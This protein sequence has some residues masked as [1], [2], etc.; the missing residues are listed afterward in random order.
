[1]LPVRQFRLRFSWICNEKIGIWKYI[2]PQTSAGC[3]FV[4]IGNCL[5]SS[6]W[7]YSGC[8]RCSMS[9]GCQSNSSYSQYCYRARTHRTQAPIQRATG[10]STWD[11]R[12]TAAT[13]PLRTTTDPNRNNTPWIRPPPRLFCH[14]TRKSHR[15]CFNRGFPSIF[16]LPGGV[17]RILVYGQSVRFYY[18]G[19]LNS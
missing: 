14:S 16:W 12:R 2:K 10:W 19:Y 11:T 3:S 4:S 6:C 7:R 5:S 13:R 15:S 1:M 17:F 9:I 8:W 18:E